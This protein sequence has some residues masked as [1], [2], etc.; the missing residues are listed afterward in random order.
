MPAILKIAVA[1]G[2]VTV[3]TG[4]HLHAALNGN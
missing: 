1:A 4:Q 3:T 2:A